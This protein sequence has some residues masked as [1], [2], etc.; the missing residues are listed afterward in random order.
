M[1]SR[2]EEVD[3]QEVRIGQQVTARIVGG[4]EPYVVFT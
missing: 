1:M 2:I 4:D 3:P